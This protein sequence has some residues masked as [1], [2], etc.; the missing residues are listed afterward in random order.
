M[1]GL[2][3]DRMLTDLAKRKLQIEFKLDTS[4]YEGVVAIGVGAF[5]T[6]CEAIDQRTDA[7]VAIKKIVH[8]SATST[9]ARR[10]LRE[11]YVL[12]HIHHDNLVILLDMFQNRG[13]LGTDVYLVMEL[14]EGN[15]DY[16][17]R[18]NQIMD[19]NLIAFFLY[20]ILRGLRYLHKAGIAHRDLKPSNLLVNSDCHLRIGDFGMAKL[21]QIDEFNEE[22]EEH[23]FYM[24]QQI[25]TLP[26]RAPELLFSIPEHSMNVDIWATGCI[27]A[28]MVLRHELF[29]GHNVSS[30][31]KILVMNMG[32]P[33]VRFKEMITSRETRWLLEDIGSM[34]ARQWNDI[35]EHQA[36]PEAQNLIELMVQL[37][38][39][40]RV[41]AEMAL[42]HPYLRNVKRHDDEK[43]CPFKVKMDMAAVDN[44]SHEELIETL[45]SELSSFV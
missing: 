23:S 36:T 20:Q 33:S 1:A 15:L 31:I 42:N 8:A 22:V 4:P 2:N 18:S 30:Q 35:L 38:P 5:G 26:Y 11:V 13:S 17:I 25:A 14:M 34:E 32:T 16:V 3:R 10:T 44:M 24:T 27:F 39:W 45:S 41:N 37:N 19:N 29:A 21:S 43:I 12:R 9:L 7:R 40:E 6:V 28:E